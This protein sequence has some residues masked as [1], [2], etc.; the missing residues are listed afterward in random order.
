MKIT[1]NFDSEKYEMMLKNFSN[2]NYSI[3]IKNDEITID[4]KDTDLINFVESNFE[5]TDIELINL[6]LD[7]LESLIIGEQ[8]MLSKI[9]GR[10]G[11]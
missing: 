8:S 7:A 10:L 1:K 3:E 9:R 5:Y 4:T 11:L 6:R 2:R